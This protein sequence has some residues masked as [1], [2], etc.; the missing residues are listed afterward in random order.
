MDNSVGRL[1]SLI[2]SLQWEVI[3]GSLLGD[4]R[5]ECRSRGIRHSKT[6][7]FRAHHGNNQKQYVLW[8]YQILK[9]LVSTPP[10]SITRLD[11]KRNKFET[12][13]Y[14]HTISLP[15]LGIIHE[16]FYS[17]NIKRLPVNL[18]QVFT[19]YMLAVWY[20]D[21]GSYTGSSCILNTHC[22]QMS[23][24]QRVRLMLL[25][26]FNISSTIIKDRHQYKINIGASQ[27][28][29]LMKIVSPYIIPTMS[30]KIVYPR[31]DSSLV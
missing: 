16:W 25:N 2:P 23:E 27:L 12:S 24:Q 15:E 7:R 21:D 4:G 3:I 10:K 17:D 19:P 11:N 18:E 5:L 20:M 28:N 31:N 8:K 22:L 14:F 1:Q 30:Y 26:K 9:N 6:A 13:W 29:K